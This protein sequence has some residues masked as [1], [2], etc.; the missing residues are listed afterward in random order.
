MVGV[1]AIQVAAY[2]DTGKDRFPV[3]DWSDEVAG[4]ISLPRDTFANDV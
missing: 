3:L 4:I 2:T 1:H